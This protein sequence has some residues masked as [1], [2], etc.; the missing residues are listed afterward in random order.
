VWIGVLFLIVLA[1]IYIGWILDNWHWLRWPIFVVILLL[2]VRG[3][4]GIRGPGQSGREVLGSYPLLRGW[5][6]CYV[7]C[8]I[9]FLIYGIVTGIE[10][11]KSPGKWLLLGFVPLFA[12][13]IAAG[14]YRRYKRF[15]Q[16]RNDQI[17]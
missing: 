16:Q 7:I 8:I 3:G 5:V 4:K 9:L 6:L 11:H 14:E 17:K 12:P 2:V 10:F 13:W 15:G 1:T